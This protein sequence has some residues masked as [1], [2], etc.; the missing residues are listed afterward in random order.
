MIHMVRIT[1]SNSED[2]NNRKCGTLYDFI[3]IVV[4]LERLNC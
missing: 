1:G 4:S 3:M 2:L